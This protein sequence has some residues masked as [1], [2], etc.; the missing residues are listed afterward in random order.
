MDLSER[1][2]FRLENVND[3]RQVEELTREAFWK[4]DRD[5]GLGCDEHFMVH[6]LRKTRAFIPELDF[7][8]CDGKK[9]IGHI[10][11]TCSYIATVDH[12]YEVISFGPLSVLPEYQNQGVGSA[13]VK[14]TKAMAKE[15]GYKGIFVYGN[16]KFYNRFGLIN[17]KQFNV[18]TPEGENFDYFMGLELSE[19]S[20][21]G[22]E[23]RLYQFPDFKMDKEAARIFDRTFL[24][25]EKHNN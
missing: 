14:R 6:Q 10:I 22:L 20:L 25:K 5:D 8:A 3:Y 21:K 12:L 17:A 13:L 1:F 19:H 18:T 23:G 9:I 11:Y 4:F 16:P 7:V 15:M 2:T 24:P